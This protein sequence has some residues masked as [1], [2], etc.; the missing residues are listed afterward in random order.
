MGKRMVLRV[1]R[2]RYRCQECKKTFVE[3]TPFLNDDHRLTQRAVDYI[4]QQS[5]A[6]THS[7]IA[8]ELGVDGKTVWNV[9]AAH[10]E[11]FQSLHEIITPE[12][13]GIDEIFAL[14]RA[15]CV[16]TNIR[17]NTVL[18]FLDDR[19]Q[20]TVVLWLSRLDQSEKVK[21]VTMDM[22]NPYRAAVFAVLPLATIVIDKF[23][24]LRLGN[25]GL[26]SYRKTLKS[27]LTDK[28]RRRL[29]RDRY[30]LLKRHGE[31]KPME[32]VLF[33]SWIGRFPMLSE[34]HR[35]KEEFF[36]IYDCAER[37]EA[38][39]KYEQWLASVPKELRFHFNPLIRAVRN[40]HS[41]IF[42]YFDVFPRVTNAFTES[43]NNLIGH[44]ITD[45]RGY[46]FPVLRAKVLFTKRKRLPVSRRAFDPETSS[47]FHG[48]HG[49]PCDDAGADVSTL[50]M[51]YGFMVEEA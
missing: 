6:R 36:R 51:E 43:V 15:R 3:S 7:D 23:H 13:L 5:T 50:M 27:A 31:L 19:N 47:C 37:K 22:W 17:E 20:D 10:V 46:S 30:L 32:R 11:T 26:D 24:V 39:E 9:F 35:L 34:A 44:I 49:H 41:E 25:Q 29:K 1:R 42:S 12:V 2:Q 28:E 40:W 45:G 8:R 4:Q 21:V 14:G 48:I 38:E 33:E 16:L 18:D